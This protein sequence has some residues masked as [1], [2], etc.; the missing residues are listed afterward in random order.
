M[1]KRRDRNKPLIATDTNKPLVVFGGHEINE[2]G[3]FNTNHKQILEAFATLENQIKQLNIAECKQIDECKQ[4][5]QTKIKSSLRKIKNAKVDI[6]TF[7]ILKNKDIHE[8][9]IWKLAGL[10]EETR[11]EQKQN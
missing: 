10:Y 8:D 11:P 2:L 3:D 5:E 7:F 1:A 9:E 6:A 4:L